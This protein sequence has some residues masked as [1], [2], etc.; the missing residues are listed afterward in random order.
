MTSILGTQS[1]QHPN[2][3]AS[4]TVL[5][6]GTFSSPGHVLQVLSATKTDTFTSSSTGPI[7][8][9]GL[10]VTITPKFS[11]SKIFIMFNVHIVGFDAGTGIRVLRG[12]TNIALGDAEGSRAR[13][14]AIGMYSNAASPN[15]YDGGSTN[16]SFLDSPATTSA[17][18]YKLQAQCLSTNGMVV[19][20]SRYNVDNGNASR[21]VSTITLMEI[22]Q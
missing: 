1:I 2:G 20:R 22:A 7:D 15:N 21:G 4:A 6:D 12:S 19:N 5:A 14:T 17:T 8:I 11:T 16:A 10:S 3:T 18:T 9:T 13:M